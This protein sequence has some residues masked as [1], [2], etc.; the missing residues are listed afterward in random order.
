MNKYCL[1]TTYYGLNAT[2]PSKQATKH[3]FNYDGDEQNLYINFSNNFDPSYKDHLIVG[4]SGRKD[5]IY[6]K[7]FLL[8]DFIKENIV[9]RH[10]II[11]HIDYSDVKFAQSF[12]SMMTKFDKTGLDFCIAAEKSCWP[13]LEIVQKWTNK[14]LSLQEFD[15]INSGCIISKTD[16]L[17]NYLDELSRLCLN[18]DIDFWDDQGVWQYYNINIQKLNTDKTCEYFFCTGLLDDTYYSFENN[19][20]RT[21]FNTCPYI[22][23]DNSSFSLN[24]IHQ[25]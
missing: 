13:Y 10:E 19:I 21:K 1:I 3:K 5:L 25:I 7:I 23:H 14:E 18:S 8:K 9:G 15:Y 24:L 20:I 17:L 22:I 16:T 6:S 2:C 4:N 12:N 11:C